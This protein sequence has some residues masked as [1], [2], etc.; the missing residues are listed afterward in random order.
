MRKTA[1][2][3]SNSASL[4]R[5]ATAAAFEADTDAAALRSLTRL[6][7]VAYR[8][9][10]AILHWM[11]PDRFSVFGYAHVPTFKTHQRKIEEA[12]LPDSLERHCQSEAI[13]NERPHNDFLTVW[14]SWGIGALIVYV[15]LFLGTVRNYWIARRSDDLLL[16]GLAIGCIVFIPS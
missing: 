4:V 16:R 13:G 3:E 5:E 1:D 15:A 10:S 2:Y 9:A 12:A 11:R 7:G 8:T 6:R 14:I